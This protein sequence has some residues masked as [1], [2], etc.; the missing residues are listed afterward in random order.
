MPV[1]EPVPQGIILTEKEKNISEEVLKAV[2]NAWDKLKNTSIQGFQNSF[3]QR[4]GA[5]VYKND[6]WNLRVE[7]RGYDVLLQTLPWSIGMIKTSWMDSFL[8]VEWI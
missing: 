4:T 2:L 6:A 8:Y 3:L 7:Q 5:L 1:D